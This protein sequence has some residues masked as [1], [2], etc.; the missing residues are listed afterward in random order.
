M[1]DCSDCTIVLP[2][3]VVLSKLFVES[4]SRLRLALHGRLLTG[5]LEV[6][7]CSDCALAVHAPLGTLQ[8]DLCTGEMSAFFATRDCLLAIVSAG[9]PCL[10]VTVGDDDAAGA[11]VGA[12]AGEERGDGCSQWVTRWVGGVLV[13]E[14]VV[15]DATDYPTT[16]RELAERAAAEGMDADALE[17]SLA[18]KRAAA[19]QTAGNDAFK[20]GDFASAA[21]AYTSAMAGGGSGKKDNTSAALLANRA[22]CWLKL[23][24]FEAALADSERAVEME[25]GH[26]KALFRKGLALKALGRLQEAGAALSAAQAAEPGNAAVRDAILLLQRAA[27]KAAAA[28]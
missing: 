21:A 15:R 18:E 10:R 3:G 6:W 20:A 16:R 9:V 11:D 14:K 25:P 12:A 23:G 28:G 26:V 24:R 22:A 7:R 19:Q 17:A 27:A 5:H 13:T 4:C 8:A 1:K 2:A